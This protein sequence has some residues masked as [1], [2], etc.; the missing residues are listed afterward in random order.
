MTNIFIRYIYWTECSYRTSS[1]S[2]ASMDGMNISILLTIEGRHRHFRY[3][4][5][6]HIA[7]DYENQL[8]YWLSIYENVIGVIRTDG[9][10]QR[11]ISNSS[12]DDDGINRLHIH[13][14]FFYEETL[15]LRHHAHLDTYSFTTSNFKQDWLRLPTCTSLSQN[16]KVIV[17][18]QQCKLKA[19]IILISKNSV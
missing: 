3:N 9:S 17:Q 5:P 7:I 15:Y 8:L 12:I 16:S 19:C 11:V 4:C 1:I 13:N 18:Q 10:D 2:R 6:L 14:I